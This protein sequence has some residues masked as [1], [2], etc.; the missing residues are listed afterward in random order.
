M[1]SPPLPASREWFQTTLASIGDAVIATDRQGRVVFLNPVAAVL[2]GWPEAEALGQ[3]ST[4][5]FRIVNEATRQVVENPVT[6][7]L[8]EG[9]VVGLANQTLLLG[10]D[11]VERPIDDSGAPIYD[12][13]GQLLGV[14][15]VFRDITERRQAE[16][17]RT[18]L[19]AIVESSDDAIISKTLEGIITSWNRGAERLYGYT[20]AE[21]IGQP[22]ARLIPPDL[23]DDFPMIMARLR[24][25]ERIEHYE[26]Q[27]LA[28]DGTR[29][30]VA[31][32]ISPLRDRTGQIIGASKIA[33]DITERR[34]AEAARTHL[35]AIVESADDAIISKTLEG[36]ITSWN[37]GAERLY[38]Y[39]AAE[40]IGQP[41]ARLIP[42]DLADDLP[43]DHGAAAAGR[44]HRALRDAAPGQGR[45]P[46]RGRA[47]HLPAARSHRP[48]HRR[49]QDRPRHYGAEAG[50][51]GAGAPPP[52][53]GTAGRTRPGAERLA[54]AGD[55]AP[56]HC[57][58]GTGTLWE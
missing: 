40:M 11:G 6:R 10:R 8:R 1:E 30:E 51:G 29:I 49:L 25:G 41:I 36:I 48:D 12:A 53:N 52:G 14:V 33:R 45:H 50:R 20:A 42:P 54:R 23:A 34:Q 44:T 9:T 17:A 56:A 5:V 2:T 19:A 57:Q 16:A 13:Q 4:A 32:T 24:R 47:D 46:H 7:V 55:R 35:A 22:I 15:L 26:T 21:M 3:D 37:R 39:P 58:R 38:G 28:K 43:D 27:R 31:L 18:H